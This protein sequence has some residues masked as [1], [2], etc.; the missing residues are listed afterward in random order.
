VKE[1]LAGIT[2]SDTYYAGT[3]S[4]WSIGKTI[5]AMNKVVMSTGFAYVCATKT[6]RCANIIRISITS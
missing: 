1:G 6:N 4:M 3:N 5:S 2:L